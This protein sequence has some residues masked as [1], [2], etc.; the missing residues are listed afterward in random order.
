[1]GY[2]PIGNYGII[3]D[4]YTAALVSVDGSHRLVLPAEF[5]LT[6]YFRR[7]SRRRQGRVLP[8]LGSRRGTNQADV[9]ARHERPAHTFLLPGMH[10]RGDRFHAGRAGIRRRNGAGRSA[11]GAHR[12][13]D[14]RARALPAGVPARR[15]ITRS[16][17]TK[18][19][20]AGDSLGAIFSAGTRQFALKSPFRLSRDGTAV[21]CDFTLQTNQ[22]ACFVLRHRD[23]HAD[24]SINDAPADGES[25]LAD[26]LRFWRNWAGKSRY[27]GRWRE[28]R[29]PLRPRVEAA[30]FPAHR[31]HRGRTHHQPAGADRRRA[32]LGLPLYLGARRRIHGVRP[33]A[34]G[35]RRRGGGFQRFHA[36]SRLRA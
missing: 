13:G 33:D 28:S 8:P 15:S 24:H 22:Q 34:A 29:D 20:L 21:T 2:Q 32:Q 11:V 18:C 16:S 14:Q 26:T 3:G 17:P 5:R 25:L 36:G 1:M 31:R 6:E 27:R 30:Q 10:G 4:M 12:Q 9:P 23:G 7:H 19:H 35:V